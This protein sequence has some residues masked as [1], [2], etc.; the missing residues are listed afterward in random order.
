M[1]KNKSNDYY[2]I[3]LMQIFRALWHHLWA[4][5]LAAA[6]AGFALF[7]YASFLI[8]PLYQAKA[9]MY[10]NN[11]SISVGGTSVSISSGELTA[12][13][14]LVETYSV[15]LKTRLTLNEVIEEVNLSYTYEQLYNM[16][17]VG[18][19]NSTEI[20]SITVTSSSPQE[21]EE[22]ANTVADILPDKI[23]DIVDGSSVRIVDYAVVPAAKSSPSITRYTAIGV[24][25]GVALAC[26]VIIIKEMTDTQIHN[27]EYL[28]QNYD[29]PV[30]AVIPDLFS[31]GG[32]GYYAAYEAHDSA[33]K[34]GLS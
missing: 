30:L 14:S 16:I 15:I 1:N 6:L 8:T 18:A 25:V 34:E 33:K 9:L 31:S 28:L 7:F 27:E 10:V 22:I 21:A 13:Q 12:A 4:I 3:D 17:E 32:G 20:F 26:A 19:V 29:L 11:S 5:V 24:F 23:A 2:E